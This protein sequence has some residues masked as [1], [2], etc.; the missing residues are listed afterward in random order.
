[1]TR[2]SRFGLS[3]LLLT[4]SLAYGQLPGFDEVPVFVNPPG[5]EGAGLPAPPVNI[6]RRPVLCTVTAQPLTVR[7][8]GLAELLGDL[9]ITCNGYLRANPRNRAGYP[10]GV[11][12]TAP[13]VLET[14]NIGVTLS[15][16]M[17][18]RLTAD[19][20]TEALLFINDPD[21]PTAGATSRNQN[22][23]TGSG[24]I[25]PGLVAHD[26]AFDNVLSIPGST[27]DG[28]AGA[29]TFPVT[30][31][32]QQFAT[33]NPINVFQANRT[34]SQT[35]SFNGVPISSYD[36]RANPRLLAAFNAILAA[37]GGRY[38]GQPLL[39]PWTRSFRIKNL[40]G[41]IAGA[42]S[43]NSQIFANVQIQNPSG[44]LQLSSASAVVGQVLQ[45][46]SF[47]L[48]NTTDSDGPASALTTLASCVT[49]NRD[50][51]VDAN[52]ADP[53]NGG[54][55]L[56]QFTEGYGVAFRPRGY[57]PGQPRLN[58]QF[59]PFTNYETE[60]GFYN[61]VWTGFSNGLGTAGIADSGTRLRIT[62]R[63]LPANIR[64]YTSVGGVVNT[65]ATLGAYS[66]VDGAVL[67]VAQQPTASPSTVGVILG[68]ALSGAP[69][70]AFAFVAVGSPQGIVNVPITTGSAT[71]VW[72]VYAAQAAV[73]EKINFLVAV[74]YRA[75]S[76]PGLGTAT[77]QGTFAPI[78]TTAV[79]S[80]STVPIPRFVETGSPVTAFSIVPCLTNLLFPYVTNQ[81]GFD[82]GI[83][84]S[85]TSL[86]NP[87]TGELFSLDT[88]NGVAPQSG[89]CTL[90]YFGTTGADGAA[91]PPATT[92]V[93]PAGRTFVMTLSAGATG[94]LG[95]VPAA[96][97]FQGYVIA[98]CNFRYA[99]GYAFIADRAF[100]VLAQGYIALIMDGALSHRTGNLSESLNQ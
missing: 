56:A 17:T 69:I 15:V 5:G 28:L 42:A 1:M 43:V 11:P 73:I 29:A 65:S 23:C 46:L 83:A 49:I 99:H 72:E 24:G 74:A 61:T 98:Q 7:V 16:P 95:N 44:E 78:N 26:G 97:N 41:A 66:I 21:V 100:N 54:N 36:T 10:A 32:N 9:V 67:P 84:L 63:N 8:E 45:G 76:N 59:I 87:G 57:S 52:D 70:P 75:A 71:A 37:N 18:S 48:R 53:W 3:A 90:N 30:V 91:P 93:I 22:P 13:P 92:G 27:G 62:F 55:F 6:P 89:T 88:N 85:N 81:I 34:N 40:R 86:T 58:D 25:C 2:S 79:A 82:T 64:V 31:L 96:Q 51:A 4:A 33:G 47:R 77:V 14:I 50:L 39:V 68:T 12:P 19:P 60:S 94:P 20:M 35:V 38:L 80:N